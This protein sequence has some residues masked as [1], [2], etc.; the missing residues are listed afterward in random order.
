MNVKTCNNSCRSFLC[1]VIGYVETWK[2]NIE[3][4]VASVFGS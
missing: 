4:E 1:H 3:I 2:E